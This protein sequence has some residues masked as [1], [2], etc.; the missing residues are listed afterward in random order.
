MR[1]CFVVAEEG[2]DRNKIE[3]EI[4]N[5]PNYFSDY[6]TVVNFITEEELLRDHSGIPME[7]L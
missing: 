2:A 6:D 4:K 3:Q 1:E 5:M 7:D